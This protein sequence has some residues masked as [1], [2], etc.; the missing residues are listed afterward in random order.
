[1]YSCWY[2]SP[3]QYQDKMQQTINETT[4]KQSSRARHW[5][6]HRWFKGTALELDQASGC[7]LEQAHGVKR[8]WPRASIPSYGLAGV[9]ATRW[10]CLNTERAK[11]D[12]PMSPQAKSP[13]KFTTDGTTF[14]TV[15]PQHVLTANWY[16][17]R[18]VLACTSQWV[19]LM[20]VL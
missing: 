19:W 13:Q 8:N 20:S 14:R 5:L 16:E 7:K 4:G 15:Y 17:C 3:L 11:H 18:A 9:Q 1:M 10:P 12:L 2:I 6:E